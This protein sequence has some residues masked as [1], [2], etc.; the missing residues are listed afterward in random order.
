[1]I[2]ISI[3]SSCSSIKYGRPIEITVIDSETQLA[4]EDIN[5]FYGLEEKK[6]KKTLYN[7]LPLGGLSY[8]FYYS[9]DSKNTDKNGKVS[10]AN[11]NNLSKGYESHETIY[12]NLNIDNGYWMSVF[13]KSQP[14]TDKNY[15]GYY[16]SNYKQCFDSEE[17]MKW[18]FQPVNGID[19]FVNGGS[20]KK[21]KES[22]IIKLRRFDAT[23]PSGMR[24][25]V[26]C[27]K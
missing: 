3:T 8:D 25:E 12:I 16:I 5:V 18:D 21:K 6:L 4:I 19:I 10:F 20:L 26:L 22:L 15:F 7:L 17:I 9:S 27:D 1:M 24:N 11:M 23:N 13:D 14:N 2:L